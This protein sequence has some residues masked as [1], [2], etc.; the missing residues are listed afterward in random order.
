ML[1]VYHYHLPYRNKAAPKL[2][3]AE[4]NVKSKLTKGH[5][6][7]TAIAS[8]IMKLFGCWLFIICTCFSNFYV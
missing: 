8:F 3:E 6:L 2:N 5:I 4:I 1:I 7:S